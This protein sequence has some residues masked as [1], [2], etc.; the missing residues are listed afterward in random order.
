[1]TTLNFVVLVTMTLKKFNSIQFIAAYSFNYDYNQFTFLM[2]VPVLV[3]L[4]LEIRGVAQV[5]LVCLTAQ[6]VLTE[7]Q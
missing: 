2:R 3:I 5:V 4:A 7:N 6:C 1:M